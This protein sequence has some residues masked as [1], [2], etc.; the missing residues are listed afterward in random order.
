MRNKRNKLTE[1]YSEYYPVVF[2]AIYTKVGNREDANDICQEIFIRLY[3][4]LE[5]VDN[6]RRWLFSAPKLVVL[7]SP[8]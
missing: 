8:C 6:I 2:S 1:I 7:E 5:N 3:E 4:S